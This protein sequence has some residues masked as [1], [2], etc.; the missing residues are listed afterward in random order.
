MDH[1]QGCL[2]CTV[3]VLAACIAL[4]FHIRSFWRNQSKS[5]ALE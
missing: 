4:P 2:L 5:L 3:A 1:P